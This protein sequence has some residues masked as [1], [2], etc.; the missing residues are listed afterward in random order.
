MHF[1]PID[2]GPFQRSLDSVLHRLFLFLFLV[3]ILA[4][5]RGQDEPIHMT[6]EFPLIFPLVQ[7]GR[8]V[9]VKF[10]ILINPTA[11]LKPGMVLRVMYILNSVN[12]DGSS[13]LVLAQRGT[14][15]EAYSRST[16]SSGDDAPKLPPE[17]AHEIEGYRRTVW[18]VSNNFVLAMAQY[19]TDAMHL[20]YSPTGKNQDLDDERFSFFDGLLVGLPNGK[21]TVL[22][23]EKESKAE[24][25]GIKAGDE[26][27]SVGGV[28][29]QND[30][31]AF[32][33]AY[34]NA[35][36]IATENEVPTYPMTLRSAGGAEARQVNIAMPPKIKGGLMDGF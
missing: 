13:D 26:L 31:N 29:T 15:E 21:V 11:V 14:Q 22:A 32:A 18:E 1:Q 9:T 24:K 5:L 17:V 19:P 23:V 10:P 35:K 7:N 28:S 3:A 12:A 33:A 25:V 2:P 20:I 30:L 27:V 36:K 6:P 8:N 4:P 16:S 34:A